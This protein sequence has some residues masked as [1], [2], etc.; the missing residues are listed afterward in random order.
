MTIVGASDGDEAVAVVGP[1]RS[2]ATSAAAVM[3]ARFLRDVTALPLSRPGI[4]RAERSPPM[5]G[6]RGAIVMP[7]ARA[8]VEAYAQ[9]AAGTDQAAMRHEGRGT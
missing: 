9:R 6:A 2:P 3:A 5:G 8:D 1:I 4:G 7:V